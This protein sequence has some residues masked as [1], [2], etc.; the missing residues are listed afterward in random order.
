MRRDLLS[1]SWCCSK[2]IHERRETVYLRSCI[3]SSIK[4]ASMRRRWRWLWKRVGIRR[5]GRR[6]T[7]RCRGW[8]NS[9]QAPKKG[10]PIPIHHPAVLISFSRSSRSCFNVG[11]VV[12]NTGLNWSVI[13]RDIALDSYSYKVYYTVAL[14]TSGPQSDQLHRWGGGVLSSR[15]RASYFTGSDNFEAPFTG[16]KLII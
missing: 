16:E 11:N 8:G 1:V 14:E 13:I 3:K 5:T 2:E 7:S 15:G 6:T 9:Q 10:R 4:L 12:E